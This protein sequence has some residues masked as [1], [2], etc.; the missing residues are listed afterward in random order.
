MQEIY[1]GDNRFS[2]YVEDEI[3]DL[4]I[5]SIDSITVVSELLGYDVFYRGYQPSVYNKIVAIYIEPIGLSMKFT[6]SLHNIFNKFNVTYVD[7]GVYKT[8][9]CYDLTYE[10][11]FKQTIS[12][13]K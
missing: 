11:M 7:S 1:L 8:C 12:R 13:I 4:F 2:F 9:N 3:A 10:E 6:L 5:N